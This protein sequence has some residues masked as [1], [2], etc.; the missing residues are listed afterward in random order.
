[1]TSWN[2]THFANVEVATVRIDN[3]FINLGELVTEDV[4]Q[5]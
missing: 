1:M 5:R 3:P 4:V 2:V